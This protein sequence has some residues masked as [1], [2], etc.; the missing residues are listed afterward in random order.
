MK[1]HYNSDATSVATTRKLKSAILA[2]EAKV[3]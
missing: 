2:T 3:E 1:L